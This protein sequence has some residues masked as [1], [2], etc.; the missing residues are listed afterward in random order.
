M[1]IGLLK[2][3]SGE[4]ATHSN[5][6]CVSVGKEHRLKSSTQTPKTL[7]WKR[8]R[9]IETEKE[10]KTEIEREGEKCLCAH[11]SKGT[12][13]NEKKVLKEKICIGLILEV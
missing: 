4:G 9:E 13:M 5:I 6:S 8:E 10:R 3:N 7:V 11:V 12:N 1:T 2:L